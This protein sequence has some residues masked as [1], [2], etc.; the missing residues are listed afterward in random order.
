MENLSDVH[1]YCC[2][3]QRKK[4]QFTSSKPNNDDSASAVTSSGSNG[5]WSQDGNG[6]QHQEAV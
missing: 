4:G 2:R 6:S 5:S 3:M 1:D